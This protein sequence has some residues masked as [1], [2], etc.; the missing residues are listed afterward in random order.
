MQLQVVATGEGHRLRGDD[1]AAVARDV[2]L[3]NAFLAHLV[4]RCFS[5]ATVRAYA[6]DLL[7]FSRFLTGRGATVGEV[8]ATDLFDYLDWQQRPPARKGTRVVQTKLVPATTEAPG[9]GWRSCVPSPS[10]TADG[11]KLLTERAAA[12]PSGWSCPRRV[13]MPLMRPSTRDGQPALCRARSWW[14]ATR[15]CHNAGLRSSSEVFAPAGSAR[16]R[17]RRTGGSAR[18]PVPAT[19]CP[20]RVRLFTDGSTRC[21]LLISYMVLTSWTGDSRGNRG[22]MRAPDPRL[23]PRQGR[24]RADERLRCS[25]TPRPS[26]SGCSRG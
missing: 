25:A 24:A 6:Y 7:N 8:V 21:R 12:P 26:S 13:R 23:R 16:S 9:S 20:R 3:A 2:E 5:P 10:R 18:D 4:V 17:R 14:R 1:G 19:R 22:S 15:R 11:R